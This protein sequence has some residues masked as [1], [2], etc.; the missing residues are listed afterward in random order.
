MICRNCKIEVP[1]N[2]D[3][4]PYC[5]K[6]LASSVSE[7]SNS[8]RE[9]NKIDFSD[10]ENR[11]KDAQENTKTSGNSEDT[12]SRRRKITLMVGITAILLV[13]ITATAVFATGE[14]TKKTSNEEQSI[15][16]PTNEMA[17]EAEQNPSDEPVV[18]EESVPA[19][20]E[21]VVEEEEPVPVEKEETVEDEEPA[22]GEKEEAV[23]EEESVP[24]EKEEPEEAVEPVPVE[25]EEPEEVDTS[26]KEKKTPF[27]GIWCGA[28][29]DE[30]GAESIASSLRENGLPAE[31]FIT[32]DWSNLNTERWYV[33]SAGTYNSKEEAEQVLPQVKAYNENAYIKYSGEW[34]Q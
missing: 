18:K 28:S 24:A 4:C 2:M 34:I 20:K 1:D 30:A 13:V 5:G 9:L 8:K 17:Q 33:I 12:G 23:E 6:R 19:E 32:T 14:G 27:Y 3:Y 15:T 11:D 22:P 7:N 25:K 10:K 21:E 26:T 29:K 31:I 16:A